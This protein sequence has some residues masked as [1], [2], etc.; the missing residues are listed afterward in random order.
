MSTA[1]G[2]TLLAGPA[3]AAAGVE[4]LGGW[5]PLKNVQS[6]LCATVSVDA[7]GDFLTLRVCDLDNTAQQLLPMPR[8]VDGKRYF[9]IYHFATRKCVTADGDAVLL[10]DCAYGADQLWTENAAVAPAGSFRVTHARSGKVL[11][12]LGT[13]EGDRVGLGPHRAVPSQLWRTTG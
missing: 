9:G 3:L 1:M 10:K 11:E 4:P 2:A 5:R 7:A 6:K 8:T 12:A 13:G